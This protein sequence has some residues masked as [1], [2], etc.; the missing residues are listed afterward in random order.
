MTGIKIQG[1][2]SECSPRRSS[3]PLNNRSSKQMGRSRYTITDPDKPHFLTC[4]VV[5]WLPIFTRP[6]TF[7]ILLNCR[8]YQQ[9]NQGLR[10][11]GYVVLVN[12]C[13]FIAQAASLNKC[14]SSFK[15][16]TVR[17]IIDM[18]KQRNAEMLLKRLRFAK[19]AHKQDRPGLPILARG[20]SC[21]AD[22]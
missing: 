17:K 3:V 2:K 22:L 20:H 15:S 12:H 4:T 11:Y 13:H 9:E 19:L 14:V 8:R 5:E 18:L 21:R 6:E 16:F 1:H 7:D 10:L